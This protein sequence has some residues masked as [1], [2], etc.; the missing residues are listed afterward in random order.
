LIGG[1]ARSQIW[2]QVIQRLSGRPI[3]IPTATEL[4]ALGAAVQAAA[5]LENVDPLSVAARW[6]TSEG[7]LLEPVVR[8]IETI[9]RHRGVRQLAL[10][11]LEFR[12]GAR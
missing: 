3:A 6:N 7:T 5:T 12:R 2:R 9:A 8:D 1:G 11:A 4:V 10:A